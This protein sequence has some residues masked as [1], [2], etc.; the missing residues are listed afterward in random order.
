LY[1]DGQNDALDQRPLLCCVGGR[2]EECGHRGE[3]LRRPLKIERSLWHRRCLGLG[4]WAVGRLI[5]ARPA[6][7]DA[8]R[9]VGY[10]PDIGPLKALLFAACHMPSL[11]GNNVRHGHGRDAERFND[12]GKCYD[13]WRGLGILQV[14]VGLAICGM[15]PAVRGASLMAWSSQAQKVSRLVISTIPPGPARPLQ[16]CERRPRGQDR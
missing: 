3:N 15:P 12:V 7:I 4:C 13:Q 16:Q 10:R 9:Q 11:R 5:V 2:V 1:P 8:G 6:G 14:E